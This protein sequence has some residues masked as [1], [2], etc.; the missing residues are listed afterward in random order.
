MNNEKKIVNPRA[1]DK[2]GFL[3]ITRRPG[4]GIMLGDGMHVVVTKIY[5]GQVRL[6]IYAPRDVKI[7][8]TE[9]AEKRDGSGS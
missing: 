2:I 3:V 7:S 6:S 8:K 4:E 5:N 1:D 9:T